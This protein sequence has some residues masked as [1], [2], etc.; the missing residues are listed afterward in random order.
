MYEYWVT[1]KMP[2]RLSPATS[3]GESP[4][5]RLR[6]S[7]LDRRGTALPAVRTLRAVLVYDRW[8]ENSNEKVKE[9]LG[10]P[11]AAVVCARALK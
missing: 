3:L 7:L 10:L 9:V 6:S 4:P 5:R 11:R 1:V 8:K 2:R